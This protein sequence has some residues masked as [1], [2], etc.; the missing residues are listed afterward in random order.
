MSR[1]EYHPYCAYALDNR[2]R[3]YVYRLAINQ[4]PSHLTLPEGLMW[5][6]FNDD[7]EL[8]NDWRSPKMYQPWDDRFEEGVST[9][10]I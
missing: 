5:A 8:P 1:I 9:Y 2:S 3:L 10:E 6:T 4:R 7:A